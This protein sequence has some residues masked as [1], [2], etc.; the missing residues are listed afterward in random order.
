MEREKKLTPKQEQF[1]REYLIDLNATQAAIRAGFS[2]RNAS[3]IATQLLGKSH[4][5]AAIAAAM[6]KRA[7]EN[8]LDADRVLKEL[9]RLAFFDIGKAFNDDGTIKLLHEMDEGT[10][11]AIVGLEVLAIDADGAQIGTLRKVKFADKKGAL[12]TLAKHL[13]LL[14]ERVKVSGDAENPIRLM[15]MEVQGRI[16]KPV[17]QRS[18]MPTTIDRDNDFQNRN[19][20][21]KI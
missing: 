12:D 1:V 18:I 14:V 21:S 19:Q 10:R 5:G 6:K 4:V 7:D 8:K 3:R 16:L 9:M 17:P 11:R 15:V 13:G 2:E 20:W